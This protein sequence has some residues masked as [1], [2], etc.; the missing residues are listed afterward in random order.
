M[1]IAAP[2]AHLLRQ[3]SRFDPANTALVLAGPTSPDHAALLG[4]ARASAILTVHLLRDGEAGPRQADGL[5]VVR[6]HGA[7]PFL[8]S[9]IDL[10]LR[11]N[12]IRAVVVIGADAARVAA[13]AYDADR[14]G[15]DVIEADG[16]GERRIMVPCAS[17]AASALVSAWRAA[18]DGPRAWQ[19][20]VK[21]A[22]LTRPLADRLAPARTALLVIDVLND[23]CSAGGVIDATAVATPAVQAALPRI[24]AL[25][26][27]A[28]AAGVHVVHI[29]ALYG[30]LYRGPGS[31]YRYPSRNTAEGAVWSASAADLV[32]GEAGFDPTMVE[33]CL[34]D[35]W[36]RDF[37]DV[38]RP[39][40]G[41]A[42]VAK[43]RY[44]ALID[45]DL[46]RILRERGIDS[47]VL[48]GVTTNCCVESTARDLSMT[49][50]F[51]VVA[52]DCV[53]VKDLVMHLH[54]ASLEQIRTYFGVVT[55]SA[56]IAEMWSAR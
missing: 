25:I 50:R 15:Y 39:L 42:V 27:A 23:F 7:S 48:C 55:P 47:V 18:G 45:T 54:H 19:P 17:V 26:G 44:S 13:F 16:P 14:F 10:V 12:G 32:P 49:D 8:E 40:P 34:A 9:D 52:E 30:P 11:A 24:A 29:Q 43:H 1:T 3:V 53:A 51:T 2:P 46:E 21:A 37:L 20:A 35:S 4:Q 36:G 6:H 5:A 41:E 28:R 56:R 31:P 22:Y 38:A 33:L